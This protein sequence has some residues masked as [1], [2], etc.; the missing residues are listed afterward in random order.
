MGSLVNSTKHLRIM[1][2]LYNLFR[3]IEANRV[4]PNSFH[5]ASI[6]LIPKPNKHIT[7]IDPYL[8][9]NRCENLMLNISKS[10]PT[11]YEKNYT[12]RLNDT[13]SSMQVWFNT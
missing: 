6:S 2:I 8:Y 4:I 9:E 13:Y 5:E 10:N 1:S 3:K 12:L 11:M 7:T